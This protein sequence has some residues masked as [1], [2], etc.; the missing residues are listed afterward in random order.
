MKHKL[1]IMYSWLVRTCFYFLPDIPVLMRLRGFF[2]GLG[3]YSS[4][5][6]FQVSSS[7]RLVCLEKMSVGN[8]VYIAH[9]C[10]FIGNGRIL[11]NDEVLFGPNVVA[12]AS[13]HQLSG[14]SYRFSASKPREIIIGRGCWVGANVTLIGDVNIADSSIVA[15]GSVAK[16]NLDKPSSLYGGIPAKR[17]NNNPL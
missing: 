8:N 4:G 5:Y 11:I 15:G 6:D 17:I 9:Q 1:L 13:E 12:V 16:G 10:I 14:G 2:Y 3:M 7:V